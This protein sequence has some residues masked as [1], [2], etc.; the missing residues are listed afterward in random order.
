MHSTMQTGMVQANG[1]GVPWIVPATG[2]GVLW[3]APVNSQVVSMSCH[4]QA[5]TH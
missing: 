5:C 1:L 4:Q 2:L 3:T